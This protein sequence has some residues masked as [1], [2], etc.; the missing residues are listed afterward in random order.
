MTKTLWI[1]ALALVCV[2]TAGGVEAQELLLAQEAPRA[3]VHLSHVRAVLESPGVVLPAQ[4]RLGARRGVELRSDLGE[5]N[6]AVELSRHTVLNHGEE[7]LFV[8][9]LPTVDGHL[10]RRLVGRAILRE[11]GE[12]LPPRLVIELDVETLGD[13][14]VNNYYLTT[15]DLSDSLASERHGAAR[16][17][18]IAEVLAGQL[19]FVS[20]VADGEIDL[21]VRSEGVATVAA[22]CVTSV[23]CS[24]TT[25][26]IC[27]C[28][29][30]QEAGEYVCGRPKPGGIAPG[31]WGW[32]PG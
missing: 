19:K 32:C 17:A 30:R 22:D 1:G 11:V 5:V 2:W 31:C 12:G 24:S 14:S 27:Q 21:L 18:E 3:E 25:V 26:G 8:Y 28:V 13:G 7:A 23:F 15:A 16:V 6:A 9:G 4:V 10:E 29:W 20:R